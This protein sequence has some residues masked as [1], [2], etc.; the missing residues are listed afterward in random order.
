MK[1]ICYDVCIYGS[2]ISAAAAA[3]ALQKR[4]RSVLLITPNGFT[5]SE[6]TDAFLPE[7]TEG[8]S[9]T[10]DALIADL[11]Q[12]GGVRDIYAD[13]CILQLRLLQMLSSTTILYYA[14]PAGIIDK[15]DRVK[16]LLLAAKDGISCVRAKC[17]IDA[18]EDLE[19]IRYAQ[20]ELRC[21][22]GSDQF[23]VFSMELEE[24]VPPPSV[25]PE[26]VVATGSVW[27]TEHN[28]KVLNGSRTDLRRIVSAIREKNSDFAEAY[29][30]RASNRAYS[31]SGV[32]TR[33]APR[34]RNL[35][36]AGAKK[37]FTI[38][39][40]KDLLAT[41]M[42]EGER[43]ANDADSSIGS[44]PEL[45]VSP[46]EICLPAGNQQT[47]N[48]D[49]LVC[50]GGTAGSLAAIAAARAGANVLLWESMDYP[51][52]IGTGGAIPGYYYGLPGGLQ[53]EVDRRVR[54]C[55]AD[56]CS[57]RHLV[58]PDM[59]KK[60]S[61]S[62][63]HPLSKMIA[64]EE[65]LSEAGVRV[66]YGVTVCGVETSRI[67]P[68]M[69]PVLQ[70]TP[71]PPEISSLDGVEGITPRGAKRCKAKVFIDSTGDGDVAVFAGAAY[72]AGREP[73]AVQHIFS[74]PALTIA[75]AT[76]QNE[77]HEVVRNFFMINPYNI[78]AGYVDACDT[79]DVS[80]ARLAGLLA[81]DRPKYGKNGRI[82]S[83]STVLGARAS[84]QIMG[85]YRLGLGDQIRSAEFPDVI[86]YSM[87]HYDNHANDYENESSDALLWT[88]ALD[89]HWEAIGSEIPYRAMLPFGIE[90]LI[91]AC[92][93]LSLDFD[94]SQQFRMQRDM[95]RIG[96]AAGLAAA[97]AVQDQCPPRYIDIRKVQDRLAGTK[98][99][100]DPESNFHCDSWKPA[101]YYPDRRLFEL[102]DKGF[103]PSR[104]LL[105]DSVAGYCKLENALTASD[106]AERYAAA[107]KLAAGAKLSKANGQLIDCIRSRCDTFPE[108]W[109]GK[110]PLWKI[111]IAIC[112]ANGCTE[113]KHTV[114]DVLTDENCLQDQQALILAVRTLGT[115]GDQQ[116][117]KAIHTLLRR[118]D[119]AT[120]QTFP[121]WCSEQVITD[122]VS[123]K[124]ELAAFEA[125]YKLGLEKTEYL[126]KYRNDER[127]YV[128]R[129]AERVSLRV[130]GK[131]K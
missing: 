45:T 103:A 54:E 44:C 12:C 117:A 120:T 26:G 77:K 16:G 64:L 7:L 130:Y 89:G 129:A 56:L 80:R 100:Q 88:W 41:R 76:E 95:Q 68:P 17:F 111:A 128:R 22:Q 114:E 24:E 4:N 10:A 78:D 52:G 8:I 110:T 98:A 11:R 14:R 48:C 86:A 102:T 126:D 71:Q 97:T 91:V 59:E 1:D 79:R 83:F 15:G 82:I 43:L 27:N 124:L 104:D 121:Y 109:R 2:G 32:I 101:N 38:D 112:G 113:A 66:E 20:N 42:L 50:G 122:D 67:K 25:L 5:A 46:D 33:G 106:P 60:R 81:Y 57:E 90:N 39:N 105:P 9:G 40:T 37:I 107:V 63:F 28:F 34:Y 19:M 69:F 84:R 92:R 118:G 125:M 75:R 23:F 49:V 51:G 119:I 99:L 47:V 96:E 35:F 36:A 13:P 30:T 115:I 94:A 55:A 31:L 21:R 108:K 29:V 53:D 85:D 116:S 74:I 131:V 72:T 62:R 61:F 58:D 6:S 3:L 93:A 65:M 123:W 70:G 18:S 127:G 73:D 87:S